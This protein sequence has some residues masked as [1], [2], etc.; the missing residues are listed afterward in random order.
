VVFHYEKQVKGVLENRVL[1]RTFGSKMEEV[2]AG[3]RKLRNEEFHKFY[4]S[5]NI[6]R[7]IK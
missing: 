2:A 4:S 7:V 1:K 6:I 3:Q 5:P